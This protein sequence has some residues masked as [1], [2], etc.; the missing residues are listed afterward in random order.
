ME[1]ERLI[2]I[3]SE[4]MVLATW[5]GEGDVIE[6]KKVKESSDVVTPVPITT[7]KEVRLKNYLKPREERRF[8]KQW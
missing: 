4:L 1:L 8:W 2:L 7:Y 6:L 5:I 3:T